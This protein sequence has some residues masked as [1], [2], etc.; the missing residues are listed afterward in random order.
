M[1]VRKCLLPLAPLLPI[2]WFNPLLLIC[3][4]LFSAFLLRRLVLFIIMSACFS[5]PI[6][7]KKQ[8]QPFV[9]PPILP[10]LFC[11]QHWNS[12]I[13]CTGLVLRVLVLRYISPCCL[14]ICLGLHMFTFIVLL[15]QRHRNKSI[16]CLFPFAV[17]YCDPWELKGEGE[18]KRSFN[19]HGAEVSCRLFLDSY[20][21]SEC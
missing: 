7:S 13:W 19:I 18:P 20:N 4:P 14:P 5:F 21:D 8:Q 6:I 1:P 12:K 3:I 16:K 17:W 9:S 11:I 15:I 10:L 2:P